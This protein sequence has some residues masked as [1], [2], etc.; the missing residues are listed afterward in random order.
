MAYGS[1]PVPTMPVP[2]LVPFCGGPVVIAC[3]TACSPEMYGRC[4][5]EVSAVSPVPDW[6]N[7]GVLRLDEEVIAVLCARAEEQTWQGTAFDLHHMG[8]AFRRVDPR[9]TA[10]PDRS[11]EYWLNVYG[12]WGSAADD[13]RSGGLQVSHLPESGA[14]PG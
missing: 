14:R 3:A 2:W 9:A 11:P 5:A 8:G 12:F 4:G 10:F 13:E 7:S 6:K 1:T